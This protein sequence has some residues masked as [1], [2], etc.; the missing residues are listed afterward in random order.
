MLPNQRILNQG[1]DH[2]K[3]ITC[4]NRANFTASSAARQAVEYVLGQ[5]VDEE[6]VEQ[7]AA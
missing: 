6:E 1:D 7:E 4:R 3:S 2:E 5:A